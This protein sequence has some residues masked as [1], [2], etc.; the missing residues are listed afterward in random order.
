MHAVAI[1]VDG[2][3]SL[4][5]R[6]F[7]SQSARCAIIG[8]TFHKVY[9]NRVDVVQGLKGCFD[10]L[11]AGIP[12]DTIGGLDSTQIVDTELVRSLDDVETAGGFN[13]QLSPGSVGSNSQRIIVGCDLHD[14]IICGRIKCFARRRIRR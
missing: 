12:I 4:K 3:S 9:P 1:K 10:V 8:L 6:R 11:C 5:R 2:E 14:G 13:Q 7:R